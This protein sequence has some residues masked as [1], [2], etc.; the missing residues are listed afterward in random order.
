MNFTAPVN[1][2]IAT[3]PG[4]LRM[5]FNHEAVVAPGSQGLTFD[6][7]VIPSASFQEN[8]GAAALVIAS[9]VPLMASF[10]NNGRTII[11]EPVPQAAVPAQPASVPRPPTSAS[12][13]PAGTTAPPNIRRY[14]VVVDP[15]HG[16]DERGASLTSQLAEKDVTLALGRRLRQ[17]LE[18]R[19]LPTLLLRDGDITLSLDQRASLTNSARPAIYICVHAASQGNGVRV[20]TAL[21]PAAAENRGP[22]LSWDA[23]QNAFQ[24]PSR[25][26]G[27]SV[28]TDLQTK[29][30]PA[31]S[32]I[33]PLRPLNN[34]TTAALAM[35]VSPP[36]D[37]VSQ[38]NSPAYQQLI[39][40]AIA[41]GIADARD[42]LEAGR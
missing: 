7:K 4:Q 9:S 3:E 21:V 6:S 41:A 12:I 36:S 16:G 22:F 5:A 32:L 19:G 13:A 37:D 33:A 10:A 34:I 18:T 1:P 24:L 39:A 38:L 17:E 31:R 11:I 29:Q 27:T 23:A 28:V 30:I 2:M 35:E 14:F 8:N 20:Y 25:T 40:G 42:K 26:A 15:S